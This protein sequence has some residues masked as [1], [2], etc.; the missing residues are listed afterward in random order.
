MKIIELTLRKLHLN[1]SLT[2][3]LSGVVIA[4]IAWA[5]VLVSSA[6]VWDATTTAVQAAPGAF[7]NELQIRLGSN[8]FTPAEVQRAAG[9]FAIAVENSAIS[10]E[11]TLQLKAQDGAVIKEVHVQKGSAAWTI[12]LAAGEY[13]LTELGHPQWVCRITVQ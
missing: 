7:Q 3:S 13:S 4:T 8:G 10:G 5:M 6:G 2:S 9:T 11:Y 12:T 1:L